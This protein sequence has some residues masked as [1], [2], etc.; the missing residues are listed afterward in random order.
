MYRLRARG[1]LTVLAFV[2]ATAFAQVETAEP[3]PEQHYIAGVPFV[4]WG[5]AAGFDYPNWNVLN[6]SYTAASQM[7][8]RYWGVPL[9]PT[10]A[11]NPPVADA[12]GVLRHG[13]QCLAL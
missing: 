12:G 1:L 5:E 11:N 2:A 8:W 10:A 4:S 3:L 7:V 6:P 13:G 9:D